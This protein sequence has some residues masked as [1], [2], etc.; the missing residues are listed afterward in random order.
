MADHGQGTMLIFART[1]TDLFFETVWQKARALLFLRGRLFFHHLSGRRADANSGGPSVLVAYG[2]HDAMILKQCG[3][4]GA[5]VSIDRR[6][7][8]EARLL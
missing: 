3:L 1:E 7:P 5:L 8:P 4:D 2:D 6:K